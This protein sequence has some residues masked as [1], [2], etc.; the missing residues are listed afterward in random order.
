MAEGEGSD[1]DSIINFLFIL[2]KNTKE[3]TGIK[4]DLLSFCRISIL[5]FIVVQEQAAEI[6]QLKSEVKNAEEKLAN[7]DKSEK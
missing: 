4:H 5:H 6:A 7:A 1:D 2:Q 3:T